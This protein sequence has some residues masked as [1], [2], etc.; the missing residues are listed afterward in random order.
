MYFSTKFRNIFLK[1][2]YVS[3]DLALCIDIFS[4]ICP[5]H[6]IESSKNSLLHLSFIFKKKQRKLKLVSLNNN[7]V[8]IFD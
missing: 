7:K 6:L 4:D 1:I 3:C 2:Q 5:Q 8:I